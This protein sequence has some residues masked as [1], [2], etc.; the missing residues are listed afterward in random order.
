MTGAPATH[1]G[2]SLQCA[3]PAP[4]QQL[5]P[6]ST[7]QHHAEPGAW[8]GRW[9][10]AP[11]NESQGGSAQLTGWRG[12]PRCP[13]SQACREKPQ[14]PQ[15]GSGHPALTRRLL[16]HKKKEVQNPAFLHLLEALQNQLFTDTLQINP[17]PVP[18]NLR[19]EEI[20]HH[21]KRDDL[22]SFL[23]L[24]KSGNAVKVLSGDKSGRD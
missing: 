11:G 7:R 23:L 22:M 14:A 9:E 13:G 16:L 5:V 1:T 10:E 4:E 18:V 24:R 2:S 17:A 12:D 20:F 3:D 8:Q 19:T 15:A 21:L 6:D